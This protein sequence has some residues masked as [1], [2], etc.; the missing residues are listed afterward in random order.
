MNLHHLNNM[1]E[2]MVILC[3]LFLGSV[4]TNHDMNRSRCSLIDILYYVKVEFYFSTMHV[5]CSCS[6][7]IGGNVEIIEVM[8]T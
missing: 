6:F 7:K 8:H 4:T 3:V 5:V 1:D 2:N